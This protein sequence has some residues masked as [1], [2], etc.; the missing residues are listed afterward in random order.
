M[1]EWN[2]LA[3]GLTHGILLT[4][5]LLDLVFVHDS[6]LE[7]IGARLGT[8]N[9]FDYFCP[10]LCLRRS[11]L[12]FCLDGCFCLLCHGLFY[13]LVNGVLFQNRIELLQFEAFRCILLVLGTDV[14][15]GARQTG[16]F[17]LRAFQDYLNP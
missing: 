4:E 12:V 17:V 14:P 7:G 15:A 3:Y 6:L 9:G 13:F 11:F 5:E 10:V 1:Y 8:P 2:S 16:G